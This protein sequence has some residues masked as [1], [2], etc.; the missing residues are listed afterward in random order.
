MFQHDKTF[1]NSM[2]IFQNVHRK[3]KEYRTKCIRRGKDRL[4][5]STSQLPLAFQ[6][7]SDRLSELESRPC[8][9]REPAHQSTAPRVCSGPA[10]RATEDKWKTTV[11]STTAKCYRIQAS[12]TAS[13]AGRATSNLPPVSRCAS[14]PL[15]ASVSQSCW[16][17]TPSRP[18]PARTGCNGPGAQQMIG[19]CL[20]SAVIPFILLR[21]LCTLLIH[22]DGFLVCAGYLEDYDEQWTLNIYLLT[23][24]SLCIP[25]KWI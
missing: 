23:L 24:I 18:W 19:Y 25:Q 15:S 22:K 20:S 14:V 6:V 3:R 16:S 9:S 7:C 12:A 5:P 10:S 1:Q 17:P 8:W 4:V 13:R 21:F 11:S 2:K